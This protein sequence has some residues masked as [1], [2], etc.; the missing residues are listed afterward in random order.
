MPERR[1][2]LEPPH[3]GAKRTRRQ[4]V[5]RLLTVSGALAA[6][7]V[8]GDALEGEARSARLTVRPARALASATVTV[9]GAGFPPKARGQLLWQL[10]RA[11][12]QRLGGVR[13]NAKGRFTTTVRL[14]AATSGSYL[15]TAKIG[16]KKGRAAVGVR[17]PTGAPVALGIYTPGAPASAQRIADAR[18]L[19]GAAPAILM[20]YQGWG[21]S[22]GEIDAA[23][24]RRAAAAGATP[25]ITWEPWDFQ[26]GVN[27]PQFSLASIARGDHDAYV[28]RWA[29]GLAAYGGPVLLRFAHEMN[30]NWYPWGARVNGNTPEHF[31]DAWAHIW[32]IFADAG[33]TNVA[34]VWSPNVVWDQA[35]DFTPFYPGDNAVDWVAL[36]GYNFG[37]AQGGWRRFDQIFGPS[38]ARM[39]DI[40]ADKPLLIAEMASVEQGGSKAV[41]VRD[42]LGAAIPLHYPAIRAVVW[43]NERKIEFNQTVDYRIDS[44][45]PAAQAFMDAARNPYYRGVVQ[46]THWAARPAR[47]APDRNAGG[48][49]RSRRRTTNRRVRRRKN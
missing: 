15:I 4:V 8:T 20:W 22:G 42:A 33:A 45:S 34:R 24:L 3:A 49:K 19:L 29:T 47:S 25:M 31:K 21:A 6:L 44:S 5:T 17:A 43:F 16:K 2:R 18:R 9:Q 48:K 41:W 40:A 23:W 39:T 10:G 35:S 27:Q 11:G 26:R 14:P 12:A 37:S 28:Q 32:D 38:I 1:R 13:T 46:P 30:G 36:D 7:A